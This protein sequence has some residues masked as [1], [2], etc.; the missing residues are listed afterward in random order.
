MNYQIYLYYINKIINYEKT[1]YSPYLILKTSVSPKKKK[2]LKTS[3]YFFFSFK[4]RWALY[5]IIYTLFFPEFYQYLAVVIPI[6][7]RRIALA[8][9][10]FFLIITRWDPQFY[11]RVIAVSEFRIVYQLR[12]LN[13]VAIDCSQQKSFFVFCVEGQIRHFSAIYCHYSHYQ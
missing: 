12:L 2:N 1:N 7:Y 11:I 3:K 9:G 4:G 8:V 10:C 5:Y 13:H 6:P